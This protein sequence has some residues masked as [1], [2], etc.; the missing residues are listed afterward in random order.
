MT[1]NLTS[2]QST[3]EPGFSRSECLE[4][5]TKFEA[6]IEFGTLNCDRWD[7][8]GRLCDSELTPR[9]RAVIVAA[10]RAFAR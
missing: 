8:D 3:H 10:L 9:Q 1:L 7:C 4:L 6:S 5:A 2:C